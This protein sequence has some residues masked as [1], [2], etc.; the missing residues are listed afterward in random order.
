MIRDDRRASV[1]YVALLAMRQ[2][3]ERWQIRADTREDR[4]A[5]DETFAMVYEHM[6]NKVRLDHVLVIAQTTLQRS[7]LRNV[8]DEVV[9]RLVG[10]DGRTSITFIAGP[11]FHPSASF[12]K[13]NEKGHESIHT[14]T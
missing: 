7:G 9:R 14:A 4:A 13:Q 11:A 6:V 3:F 5:R 2:T 12:L 10:R 8:R 1:T